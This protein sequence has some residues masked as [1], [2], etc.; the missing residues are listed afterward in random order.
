MI[1]L[2]IIGRVSAAR[3]CSK[4]LDA[5]DARGFSG[6]L[7]AALRTSAM[8][9]EKSS[10]G[11]AR[12]G[13]PMLGCRENADDRDMMLARSAF[14]VRLK[15]LERR[16]VVLESDRSRPMFQSRYPDPVRDSGGLAAYCSG[17]PRPDLLAGRSSAI[18]RLFRA[19]SST[20]IRSCNG[21]KMWSS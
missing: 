3:N 16:W 19:A 7:E 8:P 2:G 5:M 18:R 1:S 14:D 21:L 6:P 20:E 9:I 4:Y 13:V 12:L 17:A 10:F 15:M 11:A